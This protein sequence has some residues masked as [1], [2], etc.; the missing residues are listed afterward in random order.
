[1]H[2]NL[3]IPLPNE[4]NAAYRFWEIIPGVVSWSFIFMPLLLA[5][6]NIV[7]YTYIMMGYI[8][9]W[10]I[11]AFALNIRAVFSYR[12]M[13]QHTSY[14]WQS[15]SR[16]LES[17]NICSHSNHQ[18]W[19]KT[20][21]KSF[22]QRPDHVMPSEVKHAVIIAN[23]NE[24]YEVLKM[25]IESV[26]AASR[27]MSDQLIVIL[28]YEIRGGDK[29]Q[30]QALLIETEYKDAFSHFSAV[31][32]PDD[33]PNEIR[34]KGG[35]IYCAAKYLEKYCADNNISSDNVIITTLDSDNR[36]HHKY[37]DCLTYAFSATEENSNIAYQPIPM[38]T[39]NIWDAPAPMRV[40]AV[41]N[42]YWAMVQSL[43]PHIL[44]NFSAHSQGMNSLKL[45]DYWSRRTIVEDGHQFWRSYF[46]C[47]GNYHVV[48]I[49]VPIY[50]DAVLSSTYAKTLKAQFIQ[51]RRWAWGASDIAYVA[52]SIKRNWQSMPRVDML[53]KFVR[54]FEGH[55]SWA[56][57][58]VILT[59][60]V[61]APSMLRISNYNASQLPLIASRVQTVASF[62]ILL[63]IYV[64]FK[65]LPPR[66]RRYNRR[67][68][69]WLLA[70]WALLP[71]TTLLYSSTASFNSQTR[72]MLGK[73]LGNFDVT[74]KTVYT[75][76]GKS[77][78]LDI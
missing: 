51:I 4:R 65:V 36:P 68:Y 69:V 6:L 5:Y 54:L 38:Y 19:H 17:Q 21:K 20:L 64:S 25:T 2:N 49:F 75:E 42:S 50:Q 29:I 67:R 12:K 71:V 1:M 27:H 32:H 57:A 7:L 23:Y 15:L 45:S 18:K 41:G 73:Y 34:G 28:A 39:S 72:L 47:K 59:F 9:I 70:Q 53:M 31:G 37:F 24:S 35:N 43:R 40:I 60:G 58:S 61:M 55:V 10:F 22:A 52:R 30:K 46:A 48:P 78:S 56:T 77:N 62:G 13:N 33:L 74:D 44:R 76:D 66:P 8:F 11:K 16:C 3:E 14:D 26:V 63:T